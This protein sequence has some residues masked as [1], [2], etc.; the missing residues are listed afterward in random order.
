VARF[1]ALKRQIP[2]LYA[3]VCVNLFGFHLASGQTS[4]S[5]VFAAPV[6]CVIVYRLFYWRR[7]QA[8]A[9]SPDQL[10]RHL[11]GNLKF[12]RIL[13]LLFLAWSA[14]IL[15]SG[16]PDEQQ[17]VVL[18]ASLAAIGCA[19]ALACVPTAATQ[20]LLLL[21]LPI[22]AWSVA[23][24]DM[25]HVVVGVSLAI[26][27]MLIRRMLVVQD[28]G[29]FALLESKTTLEAE[30]EKS[31]ASEERYAY[32][33]RATNDLIWDWDL[34]TNSLI[35]NNA[36]RTQL[37]Y[38]R[39]EVGRSIEW[40]EA[41]IHPDDA[42]RVNKHLRRVMESGEEKFEEEY[43]FRRSDGTYAYMFD[44]GYIIRD[45][46]GAAV[47]MVG[48]MQDLTER[49]I[50]E[51]KLLLAATRDPLTGLQNR[52]AFRQ[53][54]TAVVQAA[55]RENGRS[56]VLLLDLDDFKQVNDMLGHDAG[57]ALLK[58]L[59]GRLIAS[60]PEGF[61]VA[62]LGGDE[63]AVIAPCL[64]SEP[65]V[66]A[67][68]AAILQKLHEPFVHQGR[69]LDCGATIGAA[70]VPK[71]GRTPEEVLKSADIALYS[72]KAN[73]RGGYAIHQPIHR[74]E[75]Q[76]RLSMLSLAK[77][78]VREGR[79][80]PH[81]QP[82][83]HLADGRVVGFEALLRWR[84]GSRGLQLPDTIAAA[85]E[86]FELANAMSDRMIEQVLIDVRTWLDRGVPFGHVAINA[87]AA[88]FR[89]PDFAEG[90]L[91]RLEKAEVSTSLIHLEVTENV[92]LGRGA[93]GVGRSLN[94][95]SNAGV[96]IALDDFGT[97][98]ASLRHL[99]DF[100]VDEIKIDQSFVREM[101]VDP[102]NETIVRGVINLA[103]GLGLKAVAEGVET[104]AQADQ[105]IELGCDYGQGFLFAKAVPATRVPALVARLR[106][107]LP[108]KHAPR[109][110]LRLTAGGS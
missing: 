21:A 25:A 5:T 56:S 82:K 77:S 11:E 95:L 15:A 110:R 92:F 97:G 68:A 62:R 44:R 57:D 50:A 3:T 18:F 38:S 49:K 14:S 60:L 108:L 63:F 107:E 37:G 20:P 40:W 99:K 65:E 17:Y 4:W 106:T 52:N 70:I 93:D 59:A 46:T 47:R 29:V 89:R 10:S 84:H 78:A 66:E 34:T 2:L 22:A 101:D 30:R 31:R 58:E 64:G 76:Q 104:R 9:L 55:L 26:V 73:R 6:L 42:E 36:I 94:M 71:D 53:R 41:Q 69:I 39:E 23:S 67:C 102:G 13:C 105:L 103:K 12:T 27:V 61:E 8:D 19:V 96:S 43:R 51:E 16:T 87:A 85:F 109:S 80:M 48:A 24:G 98:Y 54:L 90:L 88:E 28:E 72:A 32:V 86:D 33:S 74:V 81:Y 100:L 75:M 35:W 7:L 83:V 79:L 45:A 91:D 1:N